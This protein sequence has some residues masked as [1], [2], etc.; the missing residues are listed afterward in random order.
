MRYSTIIVC[1]GGAGKNHKKK[2]HIMKINALKRSMF[3]V[4]KWLGKRLNLRKTEAQN[5][6][7]KKVYLNFIVMTAVLYYCFFS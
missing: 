6:T 7:Q 4:I 1:C 5:I 3:L 2:C